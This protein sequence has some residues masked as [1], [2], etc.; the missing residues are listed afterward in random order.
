M[1]S[2]SA[3]LSVLLRS[4]PTVRSERS[5]G[6]L[7]RVSG[8]DRAGWLVLVYHSGSPNESINEVG[9]LLSSEDVGA[10]GI[11]LFNC[12]VVTVDTG[13]RLS[14]FIVVWFRVCPT[15]ALSVKLDPE[16]F[17]GGVLFRFHGAFANKPK[18]IEKRYGYS[19]CSIFSSYL[20]AIEPAPT[21]ILN[22]WMWYWR[23]SVPMASLLSV[24]E[25]R[26]WV[27][28]PTPRR[29]RGC[30]G[31]HRGNWRLFAVRSPQFW[32]SGYCTKWWCKAVLIARFHAR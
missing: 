7:S 5:A 17:G 10:C 14:V 19:W 12:L 24:Q 3:A 9:V 1:G 29:S 30:P 18:M 15:P 20:F 8:W 6:S 23:S 27:L 4:S 21:V 26:F 22:S 11:E 31:R 32:V 16:H 28:C 25:L 2:I 13:L